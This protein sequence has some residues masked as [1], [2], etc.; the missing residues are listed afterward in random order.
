MLGKEIFRLA[1]VAE[2]VGLFVGFPDGD[3]VEVGHEAVQR[4]SRK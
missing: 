1:T 3:G 2:L 4:N